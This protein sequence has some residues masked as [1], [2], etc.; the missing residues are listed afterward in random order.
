MYTV[1][2]KIICGETM[3]CLHRDAER[4]A[5]NVPLA[6]ISAWKEQY[7]ISEEEMKALE[8]SAKQKDEERRA[9]MRAAHQAIQPSAQL[10]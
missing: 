4:I 2:V 10:S 7:G 8:E 3:A 5:R 6:R 1:T 9:Q